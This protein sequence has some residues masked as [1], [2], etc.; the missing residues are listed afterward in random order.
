MYE[1]AR[2]LTYLLEERRAALPELCATDLR[3]WRS[4]T[5]RGR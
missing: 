2:Q 3:C 4:L 5:R 1:L